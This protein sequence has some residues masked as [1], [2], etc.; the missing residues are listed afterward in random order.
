MQFEFIV[1]KNDGSDF[2]V[3][4]C[5]LFVMLFV[6]MIVFVKVCDGVIQLLINIILFI[7]V[8]DSV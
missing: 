2:G 5:V 6:D 3:V 7:L 8:I 1:G 4:V